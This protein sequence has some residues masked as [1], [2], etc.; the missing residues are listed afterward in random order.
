L[1]SHATCPATPRQSAANLLGLLAERGSTGGAPGD[2]SG[3]AAG[4]NA[5]RKKGGGK[6][7][8]K[9]KKSVSST[10]GDVALRFFERFPVASA[11]ASDPK[12]SSAYY[13]VLVAYGVLSGWMEKSAPNG[14]VSTLARQR[15][16]P[17]L[18]PS[19]QAAAA[20]GEEAS[21]S[22][23]MLRANACWA[24]GELATTKALPEEPTHAALL[25]T[26]TEPLGVEQPAM[27]S[28]AA[29]AIAAALHASCWPE[30]WAP[31]LTAAA[32]AAGGVMMENGGGG[33]DEND[34][35]RLR[36]L[37]LIA[38]AAEVAPEHCGFSAVATPLAAALA[39]AA[40]TRTPP[41]PATLPPLV[42]TALEA[43][44]AVVDAAQEVVEDNEEDDDGFSGAGSATH[45]SL[46]A[47][48]PHICDAL[49]RAWL[50]QA[51]GLEAWNAGGGGGGG[52]E[53]SG[54]GGGM[55][56]EGGGGGDGGQ[57]VACC[58]GDCSQLLSRALRWCPDA[59]VAAHAALLHEWDAWEEEEEEAAMSVVGD[60]VAAFTR[61]VLIVPQQL[62][63]GVSVMQPLLLAYSQFL[64]SA[65]DAAPALGAA[66]AC[67]RSHSLLALAA[68]VS[69]GP[70]DVAGVAA[71]LGSAAVGRL[72]NLDSPDLPLA[73]PLVLAVA[74]VLA[75]AAGP[76]PAHLPPNAVANW[77]RAAAR[78]LVTSGGEMTASELHLLAAA[79]LRALGGNAAP[80]AV[81][82]PGARAAAMEVALRA[83]LALRDLRAAGGGLG[84][85]R[86]NAEEEED[87]SESEDDDEDDDDS[88]GD[89]SDSDSGGGGGG[90]G[91]GS[92]EDEE[93]EAAF[94]LRYAEEAR[95]LAG[96]GEEDPDAGDVDEADDGSE[97]EL[98]GVYLGHP[99]AEATALLHWLQTQ[100]TAADLGALAATL[101]AHPIDGLEQ[102]AH[103]QSVLSSMALPAG[104]GGGGAGAGGMMSASSPGIDFGGLRL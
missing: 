60:A 42:E 18:D 80:A 96:G 100:A 24:L 17:V 2:G 5:K 14:T 59:L 92:G 98:E 103:L 48:V 63:G 8:A 71:A 93:T 65:V 27:R 37:R 31:L 89:D 25:H 46:V 3:A 53:G 40:A 79:T 76:A 36:A 86:R 54:G 33:D 84:G 32:A 67:R 43:L 19:C 68:T 69:G 47:L 85:G 55:D 4:A 56:A 72:S 38:V 22:G 50:P 99:G 29:S 20:A 23:A 39:R 9:G 94:M 6:D 26:L 30:N 104:G 95:R 13:G 78:A 12:A 97:L 66:R 45:P 74:G 70:N 87:D 101:Q 52:G 7:K 21:V 35:S 44:V 58:M 64:S 75:R 90:G 1:R 41:P 49:R 28:A 10:P 61:G 62:T 51:W 11:A 82:D 88:D 73:R 81:R 83:V 16:L 77:A 34:A 15:I 91:G 102:V 57:P